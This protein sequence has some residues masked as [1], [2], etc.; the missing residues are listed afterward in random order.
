MSGNSIAHRAA[1][2]VASAVNCRAVAPS[3]HT[4]TSAP[5][6]ALIV[7]AH[8]TGRP[9]SYKPAAQK[10][11]DPAAQVMEFASL[12]PASLNLARAGRLRFL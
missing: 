2:D 12:S 11:R 10:A 9:H 4:K 5:L 6:D 1:S 8:I 3:H 7:R